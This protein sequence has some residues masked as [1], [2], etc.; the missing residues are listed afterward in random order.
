MMQ[1]ESL[2]TGCV[3]SWLSF[4]L[5]KDLREELLSH[6]VNVCWTFKGNTKL[7]LHSHFATLS[8]IY[9]GAICSV[10]IPTLGLMGLKSNYI[11]WICRGISLQ[12]FV[13][14]FRLCFHLP[15]YLFLHVYRYNIHK[16]IYRYTPETLLFFISHFYYYLSQGQS[17]GFCKMVP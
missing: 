9:E 5:D 3:T 12:M 8:V 6:T 15:F 2:M 14:T 16:H 10:C 7:F 11:E 13:L 1:M 17:Q 4:L